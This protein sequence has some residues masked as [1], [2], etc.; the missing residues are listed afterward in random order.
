MAEAPSSPVALCLIKGASRTD[1]IYTAI[2][3]A[4]T[5]VLFR[6]MV[7]CCAVVGIQLI[8]NLNCDYQILLLLD[9]HFRRMNKHAF[10]HKQEKA[11]FLKFSFSNPDSV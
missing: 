2:Q 10:Q 1:F 8:S 6:Y 3:S 4:D 11:S 7:Y 5:R 9:S